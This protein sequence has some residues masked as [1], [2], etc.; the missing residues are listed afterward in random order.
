MQISTPYR[1]SDPTDSTSK[2]SGQ[3]LRGTAA[4]ERPVAPVLFDGGPDVQNA[5]ILEDNSLSK[6]AG[7]KAAINR[8][9][10]QDELPSLPGPHAVALNFDTSKRNKP[11][12]EEALCTGQDLLVSKILRQQYSAKYLFPMSSTNSSLDPFLHVAGEVTPHE[13]NLLH[14][15]EFISPA[16]LDILCSTACSH[17]VGR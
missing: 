2:V 13:M 3:L 10:D 11:K 6:F 16:L 1:A 14:F 12:D 8:N 9:G 17:V 5:E 15:C 7:L 4:P